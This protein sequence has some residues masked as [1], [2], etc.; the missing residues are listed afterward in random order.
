[1][2]DTESPKTPGIGKGAASKA[3]SKATASKPPAA[4]GGPKTVSKSRVAP[5]TS[6]S[7]PPAQ[8][9]A[10]TLPGAQPDEAPIAP[11]NRHE[12]RSAGK[13]R[14]GQAPFK[15]PPIGPERP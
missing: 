2:S 15:W 7:P 9:K 3:G 11:R 10:P 1:M 6:E 4:A 12:R 8:P 13:K 14:P 5:P